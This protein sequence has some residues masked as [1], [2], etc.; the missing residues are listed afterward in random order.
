MENH[1]Q[2]PP[3]AAVIYR[4][5]TGHNGQAPEL[6]PGEWYLFPAGRTPEGESIRM[7]RLE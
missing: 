2:P 6:V 5:K 1:P 4:H 7:R 3:A